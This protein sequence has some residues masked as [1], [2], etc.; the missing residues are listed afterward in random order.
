MRNRALHLLRVGVD[1]DVGEVTEIQLEGI[2]TAV[3]E[4]TH[5]PFFCKKVQHSLTSQGKMNFII[6]SS[7]VSLLVL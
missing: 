7:P 1:Q 5:Q 4:G 6:L 3:K 2:C